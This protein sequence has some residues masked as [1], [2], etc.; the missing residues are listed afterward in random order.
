[1]VGAHYLADTF[2]GALIAVLTT[3]YMAQ[4]FTKAG[5]NLTPTRHGLGASGA[6]PPWPCRRIGK[7]S[8]GRDRAGSR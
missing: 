5:I 2:A 3:H 4:L 6:A 7:A 1:V 8:I